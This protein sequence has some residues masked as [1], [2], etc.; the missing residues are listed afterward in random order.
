MTKIKHGSYQKAVLNPN[1]RAIKR[2]VQ[3]IYDNAPSR[4]SPEDRMA[5]ELLAGTIVIARQ[6]F[7]YLTNEKLS[8]MEYVS[9]SNAYRGYANS[10]YRQLRAL[11]LTPDTVS[12]AER[13][14]F[15]RGRPTDLASR[16]LGYTPRDLAREIAEE[17]EE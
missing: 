5:V 1:N 7:G 13:K 3:A 10:I 11:K 14:A 12:G 2:L 17:E 4:L 8:V 6:V 15:G 16:M 9:V